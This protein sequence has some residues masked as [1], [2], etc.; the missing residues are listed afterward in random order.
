MNDIKA[1]IKSV[2]STMQI[3]KAMELVATSKLR[4]AKARVERSRPHHEILSEAIKDISA[5]PELRSSVWSNPPQ[6]DKILTV[7]IA[8]DRGLAGGYN[9]N[10]FRLADSAAPIENQTVLPIGKKAAEYYRYRKRELYTESLE[11]ASDMSV[12]NSLSY[13]ESIARDYRDG[14][15]G[16]VIIVYTKFVSMLTQTAVTEL[17]LPLEKSEDTPKRPDPIFAGEPED[18]LE[19]IVPS[20]LGGIISAAVEESLA[21]ESAARRTAMN[22][23]N[24]NASEMIDSLMLGYNRARQAVITQEITEIVSGSGG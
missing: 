16:K 7:V 2:R 24:K 4:R 19:K 10:V 1:R 6:S 13:A 14:K 9:S 17:L 5:M 8:G 20:Y 23:A 3:T 22:A 12:G 11:Y 18:I 15:F 21:A